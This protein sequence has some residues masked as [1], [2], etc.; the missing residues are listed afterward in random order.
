[1]KKTE[2]PHQRGVFSFFTYEK[3]DKIFLPAVFGER[4]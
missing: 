3:I 1:M 4:F 2:K